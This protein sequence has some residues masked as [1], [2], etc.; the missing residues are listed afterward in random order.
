MNAQNSI[1]V[2]DP[3][4]MVGKGLYIDARVKLLYD[5]QNFYD[6]RKL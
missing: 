3:I 4:G 5:A 6:G 1:N 2:F